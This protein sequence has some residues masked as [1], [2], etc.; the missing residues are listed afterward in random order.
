V[1]DSEDGGA[2]DG[3][4]DS[5][6]APEA[7][8]S[9]W[10]GDG[11]HG[12]DEACEDDDLGGASC[13]D[14]GY[15][16]GALGW[17][18]ACDLDESGCEPCGNG[19]AGDGEQCDG[20][21]FGGS[22]CTSF[23][24]AGGALDCSEACTIGTAGCHHCGDG[25][26]DAGE[27]CDGEAL[28]GQTCPGLGYRAGTLAC[29]AACAFDVARCEWCGDGRIEIP[30]VCDGADL[31]GGSCED[32]G[33]DGGD[34]AC[35]AACAQD[36]SGCRLCGNGIVEPGEPCDDANAV[37][38]DGCHRC[39]IREFAVNVYTTGDQAE[40]DTA[41]NDGG[42]V[43]VVWQSDGQ[44]GSGQG[45]YARLWDATGTVARDEFRVN[46]YTTGAQYDPSVAMDSS[47]RFVVVWTSFAQDGSSYGV[48]GQRYDATG[49]A[50]GSEFRVNDTTTNAQ[51]GA[52][53]AATSDGDFVVVW[54]GTVVDYR[55]LF[56]K[57][58]RADGGLIT[59]ERRVDAAATVDQGGA[60]VALAGIRYLATWSEGE[61]Y[62]DSEVFQSDGTTRSRVSSGTAD[63]RSAAVSMP[64]TA[65]HVVAWQGDPGYLTYED[66]IYFRRYCVDC[67]TTNV[68]VTAVD[69]VA[70]SS[71]DVAAGSDMTF[72]VVWQTP[73]ADG[74]G[75]GVYGR[76]YDAT[77]S[78]VAGQFG[79]NRFTAGDQ[80]YPAVARA[81]DGRFVVVW[82]SAAQDGAGAGVYAQ[83]YDAAGNAV[84][85]MPW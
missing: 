80:Q 51:G 21:D 8:G 82:Q 39:E 24:F 55:P 31:G 30:E 27:A 15:S 28:G 33:F 20:G 71:P 13:E 54:S 41:M 29:D 7:E 67:P 22:D 32:L 83:R 17:T 48:Y 25:D 60:A 63:G 9:G 62:S 65:F 23:G 70:D 5:A 45:V 42:R 69:M 84:G 1:N 76:R 14:L 78:S 72:V 53:V 61:D 81:T 57:R 68:A 26:I 85:R 44:D 4:G 3:G 40:P 50:V 73:A 12:V 16:G 6:D 75:A 77:G 47:G 66:S 19:V 64:A 38:W 2:E 11:V 46:T 43:V 36:A 10:C 58:Y 37:E 74:S 79:V 52:D 49:A 18:A 35:T 34:L 56:S 59:G